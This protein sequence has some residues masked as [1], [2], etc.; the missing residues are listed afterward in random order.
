MAPQKEL[1]EE[2]LVA[3]SG[4]GGITRELQQY[5]DSC[6]D[7]CCHAALLLDRGEHLSAGLQISRVVGC[8]S[9]KVK[10]N[11]KI[12]LRS[13]PANLRICLAFF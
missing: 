13:A 8:R 3:P 2:L 9:Q 6:N 12:L 4:E 7:G 1:T 10:K 5:L 11:A